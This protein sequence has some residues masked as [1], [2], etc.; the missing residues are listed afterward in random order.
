MEVDQCFTSLICIDRHQSCYGISQ[1]FE[2]I[3]SLVRKKSASLN[4]I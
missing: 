1:K 4:V 2:I 3:C